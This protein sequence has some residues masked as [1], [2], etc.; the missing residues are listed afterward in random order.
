[1]LAPLT[2]RRMNVHKLVGRNFKRIRLEKRMTQEEVATVS[3]FSQQYLS[4]LENGT[5]NPSI[6][7][8]AEIAQAL[9]V[10]FWDLVRP[11]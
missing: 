1:M 6:K 3:G 5:R 9:G 4:G 11:D 2:L 7:S 8:L 10:S